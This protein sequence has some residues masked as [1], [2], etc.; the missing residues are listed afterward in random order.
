MALDKE[1]YRQAQAWYREWNV[2]ETRQRYRQAGKLL[3]QEA[4]KQY[5]GLW[6]FAMKLSPEP[7]ELHIRLH[8]AEREAY[9][10]R[11]RRFEA[12]RREHGKRA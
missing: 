8:E 1:L 7:G 6:E 2:A 5:V 4:W 3:P 10:A 9:Y 12:W 11:L